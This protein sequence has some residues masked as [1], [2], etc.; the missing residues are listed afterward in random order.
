VQTSDPR[1][2]GPPQREPGSARRPPWH[3]SRRDLLRGLAAIG[4]AGV[5]AGCDLL[6]SPEPQPD[7][8]LGFLDQTRALLA[9]YEA[10]ITADPAAGAE[11]GTIR[12]AH[13]AHVQELIALIRPPSAAASAPAQSSVATTIAGLRTAETAA[14]RSAYDTCLT[15]PAQRATLLGEIAA[16]R[17]TH[18]AALL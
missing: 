3:A 9:D 7:P 5:L 4:A 1:A 8:L 15:V 16:A 12:D 13:A 14:A 18:L 11:L 6:S 10:A 2:A 17:A